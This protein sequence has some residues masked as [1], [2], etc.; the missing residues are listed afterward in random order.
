MPRK[1]ELLIKMSLKESYSIVHVGK[2]VFDRITI[3]NGLK[4]GDAPS[5]ML[6]NFALEYD[7]MRVQEKQDGLKLSGTHQVLAD[8]D[9]VNILRGSIHTLQVNSGTLLA[10]TKAIGLEIYADKLNTRSYF[11]IRMQDEFSV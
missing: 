10:S 9:D 2:N 6:F 3:R 11:E 1:L 7:V 5:P 8:A 4:Q